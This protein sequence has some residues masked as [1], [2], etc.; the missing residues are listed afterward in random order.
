MR[1]G[2]KGCVQS[3]NNIYLVSFPFHFVTRKLLTFVFLV[4]NL[5][6]YKLRIYQKKNLM[7]KKENVP[8]ESEVEEE[9]QKDL[10]EEE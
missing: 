7:K 1:F 6:S 4:T 5:Q 8:E 2:P 9:E 3:F 10:A